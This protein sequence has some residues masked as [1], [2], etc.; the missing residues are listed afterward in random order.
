MLIRPESRVLAMRKVN[1]FMSSN[2]DAMIV[3]G[4]WRLTKSKLRHA[5]HDDNM[6]G[7]ESSP[8]TINTVPVILPDAKLVGSLINHRFHVHDGFV[9]RSARVSV[10]PETVQTLTRVNSL[11]MSIELS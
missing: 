2:R 8:S 4:G 1:R 6:K 11:I 3:H 5:N 9:L 10:T 7:Q